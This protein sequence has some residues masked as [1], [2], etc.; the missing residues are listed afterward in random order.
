MAR[1]KD[2]EGTLN[3]ILDVAEQ[4]FMEKGYEHTSIQ[5]I[6]NGLGG[7]SKGAIY[8]HFK[9]KDEIFMAVNDRAHASHYVLLDQ[10]ANDDRLTGLEKLKA[11]FRVSAGRSG[12]DP[13]VQAAPDVLGD[14]HLFTATMRNIISDVTPHYFLPLIE[15]GVADGSIKTKHPEQLAE[16]ITLTTNMWLSPLIYGGDP[17]LAEGRVQLFNDILNSLGLDIMDEQMMRDYVNYCHAVAKAKA[18]SVRKG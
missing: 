18:K 13:V 12:D 1:R 6:I 16:F 5:D 8:H 14:P 9:S 4:L 7:L 17:S 15:A 10:I 3:L 11:I 2:P